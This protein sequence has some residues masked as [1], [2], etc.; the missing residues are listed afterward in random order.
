M[1]EN[2]NLKIDEDVQGRLKADWNAYWKGFMSFSAIETARFS[3]IKWAYERLLRKLSVRERPQFCELGAGTGSLSRYLGEKYQADIT[4]VDSNS[5][6]IAISQKTFEKFPYSFSCLQQ[7][8]FDLGKYSR[9]FDLV[10][11]GGLIEHFVSE[12]REAIIKAHVD[13]VKEGGYILILVPTPNLWYRFLNEGVF[14]FLHL[15]DQIPEVPWSLFELKTVLQKYGFEI[16]AQTSV[17]TELGI[18]A[19]KIS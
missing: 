10:H 8:I 9:Q 12:A 11:S 17:V 2:K 7:D 15:L 13:L 1:G 6:A 4:I 3:L 14:K 18:L 16:L 19:R 5:R